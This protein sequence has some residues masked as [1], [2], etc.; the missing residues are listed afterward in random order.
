MKFHDDHD[1]AYGGDDNEERPQEPGR[2]DPD[3]RSLDKC[4]DLFI[5]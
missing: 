3:I 2:S 4:H 1:R 5:R